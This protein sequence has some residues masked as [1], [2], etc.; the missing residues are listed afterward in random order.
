MLDFENVT[1]IGKDSSGQGEDYTPN[2]FTSTGTGIDLLLDFPQNDS[3]TDTVTVSGEIYG[4]YCTFNALD[5]GN[6]VTLSNGNLDAGC[7]SSSKDGVMGSIGVSSG[8]WYWEIEVTSNNTD[9]NVAWYWYCKKKQL[10]I[11]KT[12]HHHQLQILVLT[13][14][15]VT[16]ETSG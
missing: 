9:Q 8:K 16:M 12:T 15:V 7:T 13:S 4:N 11:I 10:D 14:T 5:K 2:N 3:T 1:E 6:E